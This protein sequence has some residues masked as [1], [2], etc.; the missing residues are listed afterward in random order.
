MPLHTYE[1]LECPWTGDRVV[2]SED[3]DKQYCPE[4]WGPLKREEI[5]MTAP[6]NTDGEYQMKAVLSSGKE[7]EGHFGA[8]A[9]KR[10]KKQ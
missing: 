8:P 3:R 1:C 9:K 7:V 5:S 2:K 10:K 4:C 6:P